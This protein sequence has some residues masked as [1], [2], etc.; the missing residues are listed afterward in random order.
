VGDYRILYEIDDAN[1]A[2]LVVETH[3]DLSTKAGRKHGLN[4]RVQGRLYR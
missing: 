1:L 4:D 2:S 3:I